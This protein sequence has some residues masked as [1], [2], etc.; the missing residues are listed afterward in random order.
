MVRKHEIGGEYGGLPLVLYPLSNNQPVSSQYLA[1]FP[2]VSSSI[3]E[4]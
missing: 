1:M 3:Q 4:N 2:L